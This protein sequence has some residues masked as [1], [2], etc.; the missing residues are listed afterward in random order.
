[1]ELLLGVVIGLFVGLMMR[2]GS[3]ENT[4]S[5]DAIRRELELSARAEKDDAIAAGIRKAAMQVA[6]P[7]LYGESNIKPVAAV[8]LVE[9]PTSATPALSRDVHSL[10]SVSVLLYFGAFLMVAG[11]GLF[12]GLSD[13][14][15][16]IKT[17]AVLAMALAF[18][19]A[20]LLM[21]A[22]MDRLKPVALTLTAIGLICLPLAG[23]AAYFY[24]TDASN[25]PF[26]W[27]ITSLVSLLL[28][29]FAL[30]R[31]RQSLIG[32][33]SVFMCLSLWLS[34]VS[35]INAPVYFFGWA[36]IVLAAAYVLVAKYLR[37]EHE[38]GAPLSVSASVIV[39]VALALT[40]VFGFGSI[41]LTHMGITVLLSAAFYALV[42]WQEKNESLRTTY[43]ALSYIIVPL[44][45]LLI[46]E[47]FTH[48]ALVLAWTASVVS[49]VQLAAAS[50]WKKKHE[51]W[52]HSALAVSAVSLVISSLIAPPYF[53]L[54]GDWSQYCWL[55]GFNVAA[56]LVITLWT[57]DRL[58]AALGLLGV[59]VLPALIAY[60]A[61]NPVLPATTVSGVY[62]VL[63]TLLMVVGHRIR[64]F[65]FYD[66]TAS[67]Y[68]LALIVAWIVGAG[69]HTW[70]PMVVSICVALLL[71]VASLYEKLP[72]VMYAS[73]L[74][75][76]T[77]VVQFFGW[78]HA[79]ESWV[80]PL[81]TGALSLIYYL[82]AKMAEKKFKAYAEPWLVSGLAGLYLSTFVAIAFDGIDW[83]A[84]S[85]AIV[86]GAVTTYESYALKQRVGMYAGGG[87]MLVALQMALYCVHIR[88]WEIYWH[89]WALYM[90]GLAWLA[91]RGKRADEKQS[92]TMLA[93]AFQ[94][95]PLAWQA[96]GGDTSLGF[97]LLF[98]SIVIMLFGL[99]IKYRL[100]MWWGL[101]VAV[102]SVLYQLREFQFFVLVIMG[103]GVIG[104][105]V[106]LLVRQEKKS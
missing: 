30:W 68:V 98:E 71:K 70:V 44:G 51:P 57:R 97:V 43:F 26:I 36:A 39:P 35:V 77:A 64:A 45:I 96:L 76:L 38:V 58:H 19:A 3:P 2:K 88:D 22:T 49:L 33:L 40:F 105:G 34:I 32:Y 6:N 5:R 103:A 74:L 55:L 65:G 15:G 10:D 69:G 79:S 11:V 31:I 48:E 101:A 66:L 81:V 72:A 99:W 62:L 50:L 23:V 92:F 87:V 56:H 94:T 12:V 60:F 75:G 86:A 8:K 67:A 18:Y 95:V 17:F 4:S 82:G 37:L 42:T 16:S 1:M 28:Y 21:H 106:Y 14:S 83:T 46:A 24:G 52:F 104:L 29:V 47:R 85:L 102:G 90:A 89:M 27:F 13:F 91:H 41:S 61:Y 93:L 53:G 25:G 20:G 78:H 80:L 59:L 54:H 9:H 84:I 73:A 100:V 7:T 63:A